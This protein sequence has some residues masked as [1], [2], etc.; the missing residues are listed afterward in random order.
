MK[1][2]LT[3]TLA[4]T[5]AF[6]AFA[7]EYHVAVTGNDANDGSRS[8]PFK[9]ISA[10]ASIA[11][12]G[13]VIT[14]HKGLYRERVS[15]PR[16]G[17][18]DVRRITYQAAPGEKVVITGSEPTSGWQNIGGDTWRLTL[19]NSYFG[20]F[21]PYAELIHGDWFSD[22]GRRHHTG[23]VY[24]EGDWL[25]EAAKL[26][27]VLKPAGSEP[28]WFAV[29]D[30]VPDEGPQYLLNVAWI[31]PENGAPRPADKLA[32]QKGCQLADCAEGG[33]CLG[34]IRKGDWVRFDGVDFGSG[35]TR[36]ELRGAAPNG[37]GGLVELHLD[38]PDGTLLGACEVAPTG[39]W[40]DWRSF[41]TSIKETAGVRN[42]CLVFKPKPV[43][44]KVAPNS[45]E[46]Y[47]QFPG[48]NPNKASVEINA[49]PTVF[50]PATP[51][52]DYI[53]VRGFDL[54]NAAT[55]WAPPTAAQYGVLTAFWCRGWIIEGNEIS[56]S[57]CS[58]VALGKYGDEWDNRAE[59]AEGYVGTVTRA[60]EKRWTK[61]T[62]GGH[63]VRNNHIHHCEQAGVVGSLGCAFSEVVGNEIHD[64]HI[65]RLFGGAEMAGIKFHGGIDVVIRRNH[66]YRC[67]DV[68]GIWLDWMA[69]NAQVT[70]NLLHDN[71]GGSGDMF[72]EMQHGPILVANNLFL[73]P[74]VSVELNSQGVAFAHNVF[75]GRMTNMRG[76]DRSTP[77]Q[78]PHATA[79]AGM[80]P[81]QKGDSGDH[82]FYNNLFIGESSLSVFDDAAMPCFAAGN[83]FL[84]GARASRFDSGP[85]LLP[86][87][88]PGLTLDRRHDGW[89]LTLNENQAWASAPVRKP[90][91]TAL[92]GR[93]LVSDCAYENVDG[94]PLRIATDYL[95][96]SRDPANP[97]PGPFELK[98]DGKQTYKVWPR[99]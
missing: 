30:G 1:G 25:M 95:G 52:I 11:Q 20:S 40:Q 35:T 71:V 51:G 76:D 9:T 41:S 87:F 74:G 19:P 5:L 89:V 37:A 42:L 27:D 72:L 65:R 90:V 98:S 53:T 3:S 24:V 54:R 85:V 21:N 69:Q 32:A 82:R 92:L 14:V 26:D 36:V 31:K 86:D 75:A 23:C 55:N 91:T 84:G 18:S 28:L 63:V 45:T 73:S 59:S 10:A 99:D 93:A 94:T 34:Y 97:F 50:T 96:H 79:I 88:Q 48:V 8:R 62:I 80:H 16:G 38:G 56:Y 60:L 70:E 15:P 22:N 61:A 67:G 58:G 29:V 4:I 47:A 81:A 57:K 64:I 43:Q 33:K 78:R 13:D 66:I 68:A 77:Y 7:I 46:I 44:T 12:A 39:G 49:R 2:L 17:E 6:R 83:V